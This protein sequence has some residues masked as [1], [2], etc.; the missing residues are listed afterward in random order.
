MH[1]VSGEKNGLRERKLDMTMVVKQ[2]QE[3][4]KPSVRQLLFENLMTID[5]LATDIS[6]SKSMIYQ[7][8]RRGLPT[9]KVRGRLYFEP[10]EVAQWMQRTT[11]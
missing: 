11:R 3:L 4:S 1:E 2:N 6:Y 10:R 8:V 7:W 5:E 9:K